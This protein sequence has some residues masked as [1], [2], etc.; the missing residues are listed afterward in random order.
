MTTPE[1]VFLSW[2]DVHGGID[3]MVKQCPG[4]GVVRVIGVARGGLIPAV[5]LAHRLN[6]RRVEAINVYARNRD[7]SALEVP[8]VQGFP[9]PNNEPRTVVVEDIVDT[10]RTLTVL[11]QVYPDLPVLALVSRRPE[12]RGA[13]PVPPGAWVVFPWEIE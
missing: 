4:P 8:V 7:G 2:S 11:R 12:V 1:K 6:V 3:A 9:P 13:I 10:G 5:L